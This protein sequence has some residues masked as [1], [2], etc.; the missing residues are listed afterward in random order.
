MADEKSE[1]TPEKKESTPVSSVPPHVEEKAK[2][3]DNLD[4]VYRS[5]PAELQ[6]KIGKFFKGQFDVFATNHNEEVQAAVKAVDD[7]ISSLEQKLSLKDKEIQKLSEKI[8]G[9]TNAY[10]FDQISTARNSINAKYEQTFAALAESKGYEPG[11]VAYE[12][13]FD[14]AVKAGNQIARKYGLVDQSGN[15]DPLVKF[16]PDMVKESFD[17]AYDKHKGM[18]YDILEQKRK[19]ALDQ[20]RVDR[21]SEEDELKPFLDKEKLKTPQQRAKA[22]KDLLEFRLRKQGR[23]LNDFK[24]V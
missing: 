13:L 8:D 23:S 7:P 17:I 15:P 20:R 21:Q 22:L 9:V 10:Q 18:G 5:A 12:S 19:L 1:A 2:L 11:T 6:E 14:S 3:Y 16:H 4:S 24:M